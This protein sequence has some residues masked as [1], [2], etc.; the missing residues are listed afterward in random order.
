M[1]PANHDLRAWMHQVES[2][3][4]LRRIQGVSWDKDMGGLV[5]MILER[6]K[7]APAMLFEKIP[8]A[9]EDMQ[10]LC[11]QID[12][13]ERLAL[14]MGNDSKLGVT[15][16]IQAWRRKVRNFEPVDRNTLRTGLFLKIESRK[17]LISRLSRYRA[18]TNWMAD[19]ISAPTIW[20][21]SRPG[22]G[23]GK[24]GNLSCHAP[25]S[26]SSGALHLAGKTWRPAPQEI[27]RHGQTLSGR[28]VFRSPSAIVHL[29]LYRRAGQNERIR[30]R[31]RRAE[32]ADTIGAR[33]LH[34]SA[35]SGLFGNRHRRRNGP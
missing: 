6:S 29:R 3:N 27:L 20:S 15:D 8:N 5:E 34:R 4:Q 30:V 16:F 13:I 10:I 2:I 9:R 33:T 14:A 19:V 23:L 21:L 32:R 26:S 17:I 22:R 24:R 18:G 1:N 25:G 12:G 31:R 7:H 35:D 28:H 11:S